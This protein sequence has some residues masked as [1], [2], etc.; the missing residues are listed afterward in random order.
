M[1][2]FWFTLGFF[3][4]LIGLSIT[5]WFAHLW[6]DERLARF[7]SFL[8]AFST[9]AII[10]SFLFTLQNS[11]REQERR[12][13][14]IQ[15]EEN[16]KFTQQTERYWVDVERQFAS[17]YPFL[18]NLYTEIYPSAQVSAPKLVGDQIVEDQNKTW[19]MCS[20]LLQVIENVVN[21]SR[22]SSS[23]TYGWTEVFISWL[24]SPTLQNVWTHTKM[25]FNPVT[26]NFIDGV[27]SGQIS[28]T[29]Q[30]KTLLSSFKHKNT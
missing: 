21:T 24:K 23:E 17:A 8:G 29:N 12:K 14:A 4:L 27:I 15:D 26:Q 5:Y 19:H 25:F 10:L 18:S 1:A 9:V 7:V 11:E 22:V 3:G 28:G 13:S 16:A 20:E 6:K 30:A 2:W